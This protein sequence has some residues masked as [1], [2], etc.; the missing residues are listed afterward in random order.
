[1][2]NI[3]QLLRL[4]AVYVFLGAMA[5]A[6]LFPFAWM[7]ISATNTAVDVSKGKMSFGSA[8]FTNYAKFSAA[9]DVPHIFWNSGKLAAVGSLLTLLIA[10][11]AGYGFEMFRSAARE[12]VY[13]A[14]LLS[15]MIPFSALVI[16][17][18][19]L[20]ASVGLLD[21]HTAVLLPII[22]SAFLIFYFRQSTK[23]FP[24]ELRDAA[25]IDGL[26]EWQIFLF[27]YVPV[28]RSTYAA[29]FIIVFM[30]IWNSFLW[31]LI[32][33]QSPELKTITLVLSSMASAYYPDFGAIMVATVM[34]TLPTLV[35][36]FA[37]QRQFVQGMLGSVK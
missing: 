37:M 30:A 25:R 32:V 20:M 17:L 16:P 15:L 10:S 8:L 22:A 3:P 7:A 35:V 29:A 21:S 13:A 26:K 6:S 27:V 14:L 12:R 2:R 18:F 24:S 5:L 1:M 11:T 19:V 34:A 28:M 9:Y 33:L 23:A 4:A 36:F 31:P